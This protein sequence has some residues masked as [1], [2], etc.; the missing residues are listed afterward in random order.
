MPL[1]SAPLAWEWVPYWSRSVG[2]HQATVEY[3]PW[4][5]PCLYRHHHVDGRRS[6]GR[7]SPCRLCHGPLL[8]VVLF[9]IASGR[10][11][12]ARTGLPVVMAPGEGI[13]LAPLLL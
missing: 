8:P 6:A 13:Y 7:A 5:Y 12:A 11:C 1:E 9:A 4:H 3:H 10:L 2:M